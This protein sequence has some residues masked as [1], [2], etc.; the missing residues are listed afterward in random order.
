VWMNLRPRSLN[1]WLQHSRPTHQGESAC[2][3]G[4]LT[5]A[6]S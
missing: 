3:S 5:R 1:Y 4:R 6:P 2:M